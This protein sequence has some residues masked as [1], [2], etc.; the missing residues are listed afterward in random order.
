LPSSN[1][2]HLKKQV[3]K[4]VS[5][6]PTNLIMGFLGVGKTTAI[7]NLLKQKPATENWAVL[8]NEFGKIGIDGAIFKAHG[9]SVKE[10]PGGCLCCAVG[11][12]FQVAVNR[13]LAEIKPDRLLI[14]PTGLGHPKRT[15]DMLTENY[16]Q[17]TIDLRATICLV[18]PRKL[19]NSRYTMHESFIDQIA[20]ADVVVA[21]KIDLADT[22]SIQL[23]DNLIENSKPTKKINAQ[24]TQGQL[25]LDWLSL[26]R[27]RDRK[28]AYPEAHSMNNHSNQEGYQ[29]F[30][31]TFAE[32]T[33][34]D[35]KK[36]SALLSKLKAER[37][38]GLF[39]TDKGWFIF[40]VADG[41]STTTQASTALTSKVDII[42]DSVNQKVILEKFAHCVIQK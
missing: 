24:T 2:T 3:T 32:Q 8:V 11:L 5:K 21:N 26:P 35:Y 14:E 20:L 1:A 40:N 27:N 16:F 19:K 33:L 23:F 13:L 10:I 37:I 6:T 38:K 36:L 34:F 25:N 42:G 18:D 9:I 39:S 22:A 41:N 31:H 12:P 4:K 30:S 15:I 17:E 29:T 28:P 7:L